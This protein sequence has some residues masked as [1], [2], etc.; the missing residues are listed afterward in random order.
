MAK[1]DFL[2]DN[3]IFDSESGETILQTASRNGI[4]HVSACGGEGNCTTCRLLVLEGIENCS[5]ETDA[6]LSFKRKG[7]H[8]RGI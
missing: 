4:P 7:S 5:P 1:I 6:E 2:P 3:K 8:D